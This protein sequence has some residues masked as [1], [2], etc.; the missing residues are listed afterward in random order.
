[1]SEWAVAVHRP[2]LYAYVKF[3]LRYS[4]MVLIVNLNIQGDSISHFY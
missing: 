4:S 2:E 3:M 1:M